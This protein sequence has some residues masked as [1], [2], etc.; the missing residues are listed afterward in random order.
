[1]HVGSPKTGTTFLQQVLWSQRDELTEQG[2][3]L[4][5]RGFNDH[6]LACMD[7]RERHEQ[8]PQSEGAW[9]R[10][11]RQSGAWDGDALISHEL[12]AGA[13]RR[14]IERAVEDLAEAADEVHVVVTVRDLARQIPAEW[15]EHVKHRAT[16]GFEEFVRSIRERA[17]ESRWFWTVQDFPRLVRRWAEQV[18]A[19]RIH[20]VTVPPAS[21]PSD[22]LWRRFATTVGV[23]PEAFSLDVRRANTSVG[24][25]QAEMVRRLNSVLG[26]RLT[27]QGAYSV[28]VKD[29]LVHDMLSQRPGTRLSLTRAEWDFAVEHGH[30]M[31]RDLESLGVDVV[32]DL[33]DLIPQGD[34]PTHDRHPEADVERVLDEAL[35]AL[36]A[37]LE[38]HDDA[39]LRLQRRPVPP[40][41]PAPTPLAPDAGPLRRALV[42]ASRRWAWADRAKKVYKRTVQRSAPATE[43]DQTAD[44]PD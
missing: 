2:L 42:G 11:V 5:G 12:F 30:E 38:A 32:G 18:P 15:Q 25:E 29:G 36:A 19:S 16:I 41:E 17:P 9:Q 4:P 23:E 40:P 33:H 3:L 13:R 26:D 35:A 7:L 27:R 24:L 28:L 14:P 43:G 31:V 37:S 21:A 34:P 44:Q 20:V 10:L 22:L 1:M 8:V 6:W 39:R